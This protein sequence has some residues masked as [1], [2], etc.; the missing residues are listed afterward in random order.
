RRRTSTSRPDSTRGTLSIVVACGRNGLA[1]PLR[2]P[3]HGAREPEKPRARS[4][5]PPRDRDADESR[6]P[7][8]G[9]RGGARAR[10]DRGGRARDRRRA[11][12]RR[13]SFLRGR[14]HQRTPGRARGRRVPADVRLAAAADRE[15]LAGRSRLQAGAAT[16]PVLNTVAAGGMT[17]L[18]RVDGKR[19]VDL[20]P[21]AAKLRERALRLIAEV[22]GVSRARAVQAFE[23]SGRRVRI[24]IV[25]ARN[26]WDAAEASRALRAAGGSLRVVLQKLRRK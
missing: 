20:Q 11:A 26:G 15:V 6:R 22:A 18:G 7:P 23:A 24:A 16:K 19:M 5:G 25:I 17:G 9:A 1:N 4:P 3:R 8:R 12:R 2:A 21:A 14:R 10:R 13:P